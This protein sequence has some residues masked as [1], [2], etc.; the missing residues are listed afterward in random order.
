VI[1]VDENTLVSISFELK[2]GEWD[3][4]ENKKVIDVLW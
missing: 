1:I 4:R 2:S 3:R